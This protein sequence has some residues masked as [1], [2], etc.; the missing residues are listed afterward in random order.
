MRILS[1]NI[2]AGGGTRSDAITK[3]ILEEN[4]DVLVLS[5]VRAKSL[6]LLN[7]LATSG[8][9]YWLSR[10]A[11]AQCGGLAILSRA[12]F[13]VGPAFPLED[14]YPS[15]WLEVTLSAADLKIVGMYGTLKNEKYTRF[16]K[17][18]LPLLTERVSLPVLITGDLNTGQ[19]VADAPR[20]NFFCSS[21][22]AAVQNAGYVDIWRRQNPQKREYSYFHRGKRGTEPT[23]YRLDHALASPTL[24]GRFA[25]CCYLQD[26]REEHKL[27]DHAP[28]LIEVD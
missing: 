26:A 20:K 7:R 4:P 9:P 22:F 12:P 8:W 3:R 11:R 23:G 24:A 13:E 10:P 19:S 28:L 6:G 15:R 1:W 17:S 14:D 27:S 25:E 2:Q 21:H 5:E 18:V 16:W